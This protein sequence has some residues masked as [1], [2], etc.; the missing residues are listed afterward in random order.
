MHGVKKNMGETEKVIC[1]LCGK[2][3]SKN[4]LTNHELLHKNDLSSDGNLFFCIKCEA[5]FNTERKLNQHDF[6]FHQK[7]KSLKCNLCD[8]MFKYKNLL[9]KH[10]DAVHEKI[11]KFSCNICVKSYTDSTPLRK[12]MQIHLIDEKEFHIKC[13]ECEKLFQ[14]EDRLQNHMRVV[15]SSLQQQECELCQKKFSPI[16]LKRHKEAI[17]AEKILNV[18]CARSLSAILSI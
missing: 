9:Q 16:N 3:I 5:S 17:H 14:F 7:S 18:L 15:H 1:K 6:N 2:I 12:H 4:N 11:R 8:K 10:V 13:K